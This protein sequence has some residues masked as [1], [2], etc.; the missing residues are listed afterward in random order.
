VIRK[1]SITLLTGFL[2]SGK[3]TL[4]RRMLTQPGWQDT[5][6]LVNEVGEVGLDHH[7][8]SSATDAVVVMENGCIC[9][10][11]RNDL[12]AVLED[13]FWQRLHRKIPYFTRV[14]IET[15]GLA[16]PGPVAA[17]LQDN[18]L[19]A[20]R[21]ALERIVCT[22]DALRGAQTLARHRE[23]VAQAASADL[24]LVTKTDLAGAQQ[25]AALE[26]M[27]Y[28]LNPTVPVRRAGADSL[29]PDFLG[30]PVRTRGCRPALSAADAAGPA[31]R[32]RVG[33][34]TLNFVRPWEPAPFEAALRATLAR[35]GERILRV[36]GLVALAGAPGPTVVQAVQDTLFPLEALA[37]WPSGKQHSF[38]I[39]I[40]MGLDSAALAQPF[41]SHLDEVTQQEDRT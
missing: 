33:T 38:L 19:T 41:H 14:V 27:L 39:L 34:L 12:A 16:D 1:I 4:L 13:L 3:T 28:A 36:K 21:Y 30:E 2:G 29:A 31:Y 23:S 17:A 5:L 8:M 37:A 20:Q 22:A 10:S 11:V 6:V 25:V 15:T 35:Y 24:I 18:P 7:L 26:A 9:C 32:H 40:T